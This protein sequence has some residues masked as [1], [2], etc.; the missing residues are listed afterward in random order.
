MIRAAIIGAGITGSSIARVLSKYENLDVHLVEKKPDVG[1]GVSKANTGLIHP[2]HEED[3]DKHPLRAKFCVQGNRLWHQWIKELDIPANF[4]GEMMIAFGEEDLKNLKKYESWGR[5]NGVPSLRIIDG[6]EI[7]FL[8]PNISP[9]ASRALWGPT[10]GQLAP[11]G[12]VIAL[13]ENVVANGVSY[14]SR[15]RLEA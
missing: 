11:L 7:Q 15:R 8:E 9:D 13:A 5:R 1:W 4:P 10:C 2:G 12:A 3:P 14:I 6:E